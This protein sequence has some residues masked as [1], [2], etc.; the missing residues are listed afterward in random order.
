MNGRIIPNID[1]I[2]LPIGTKLLVQ[3]V[4]HTDHS[5]DCW[6]VCS[7]LQDKDDGYLFLNDDWCSGRFI[8]L[9]DDFNGITIY[10]Y[11]EEDAKRLVKEL[12]A[13]PQMET[14]ARY[15]F[16]KDHMVILDTVNNCIVCL[17]DTKRPDLLERKLGELLELANRQVG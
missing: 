7:L 2:N 12:E 8:N 3:C 15:I 4:D 6:L 1:L 14:V 11:T 13:K 9:D 10:E 5:E 16:D 17:V